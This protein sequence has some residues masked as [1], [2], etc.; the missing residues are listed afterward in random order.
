MLA[1]A[2]AASGALGV[3]ATLTAQE[4]CAEKAP[5]PSSRAPVVIGVSLGLSGNFKDFA[6]PLR[7]AIVVAEGE[8][9]AYGGLLGRPVRFD[10]QDDLSSERDDIT[11]VAQG[12]VDRN[13]LA[14]I[15]PL[16]SSQVVRTQDI[17]ARNQI[18]QIS[19]SAT[20]TELTNIQ[21]K[22]D[23]FLFRTTPA[24]D[25][26]GAAVML[27]AQRTPLGLVDGGA[28]PIDAGDGGDAAAAPVTCQK[29]AI[30]NIDNSYGNPMAD[31]VENFWPRREGR[32][33][34]IRTRVSKELQADYRAVVAEVI[35]T[36][37]ECL[38]LI[39]YDDVAAQFLRDFRA[40]PQFA[41]LG[42][43]FFFIGTDGI[44]TEGLLK[45]GAEDTS[46]LTSPNVAEGVFGTNPDTQPGT[47]EYNEFRTL[48]SSYFALGDRDAPSFAANTFDAAILLALAVQRAGT[49]TDR[50]AIRDA[51]LAV[52]RPP[53]RPITP[54]QLG[55]ALQAI[56]N[57]EDVDYK[58][59]S[60]NVDF[61]ESGNVT[62]GFIVWQA[63]RDP[64]TR[65]LDYRT[66]GRFTVEELVEL[67]R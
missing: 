32:S 56:R 39:A 22:N 40:D 26:Q 15:G 37:P 61:D 50:L 44:Y 8:I 41:S 35:A 25:F 34:T 45:N 29:L 5:A 9:N 59:A 33:I 24:D 64:S 28:P 66:V 31:L 38:A 17:L 27:L 20:S 23:R 53:G 10:V 67:T 47:K 55:E 19:P 58:G 49:A 51:M 16:G 7:S 1:A 4:G 46:D 62:G 12:F 57:G 2:L 18:L 52:S 30:V 11:R 60:G 65:I 3:L 21:P 63:A 42:S 43:R 14:V 48:Y 54:G 6:G 13:V 36:A